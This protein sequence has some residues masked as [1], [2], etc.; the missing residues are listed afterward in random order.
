MLDHKI[1]EN[2][3]T[4]FNI[5]LCGLFLWG[6]S[7]AFDDF[8]RCGLPNFELITWGIFKDIGPF[9]FYWFVMFFAT[10][11]VVPLGKRRYNV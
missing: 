5:A 3:R 9:A 2:Y 1:D 8:L 11:T 10:F 6:A 7:L 4:I